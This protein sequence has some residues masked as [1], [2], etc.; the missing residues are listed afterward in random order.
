MK[1]VMI[2]SA[3]T[4]SK[5]S[6]ICVNQD[7]FDVDLMCY[8]ST[9]FPSRQNSLQPRTLGKIPKMLAWELHPNYDYYIWIDSIFNFKRSDC[10][11]W[12]VDQLG[13]SDAAFFTHPKR[14]TVKNELD[15]CIKNMKMGD[16]HLLNKYEG[17][18]MEEQVEYYYKNGFNDNLLIAAGAFIYRSDLVANKSYNVMKEW[19]YH[20][21][22]Y[23]IQ[24]QLSLPYLLQLFNV[25]YNLINENI[26]ECKYITEKLEW[27]YF[28][29]NRKELLNIISETDFL[30]NLYKNKL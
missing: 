25:K 5:I 18:R 27:D 3:N 21:C 7:G 1:K 13:D 30:T 11:Q 6:N 8:N 23:S 14:D 2:T 4:K 9:N 19:F 15:F 22:L 26:Y 17:E 12:F 28:D 29:K 10:V 24:D 20:N 16:Q